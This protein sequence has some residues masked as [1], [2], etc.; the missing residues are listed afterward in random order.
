MSGKVVNAVLVLHGTTGSGGAFLD[1]ARERF[2]LPL[3]GPGGPLDARSHY[4]V[5]PDGIG[6]GGSSRPSDGLRMQ[7]P[8]YTYDDMVRAQHLLL[9]KHLKIDHL[10]LVTGTSMG[11]MQ[12]WLWGCMFP[13]MDALFPLPAAGRNR[14]GKPWS[15]SQ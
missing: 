13:T 3:F 14:R 6:H 8:Q 15:E 9:T 4:I 2:A 12:T 1:G 11:G 10:L 5:L 7:F